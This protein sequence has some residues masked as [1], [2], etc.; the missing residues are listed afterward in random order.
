MLRLSI[1]LKREE[2]RDRLMAVERED[3]H[4]EN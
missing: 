1:R 4:G 2:K 3:K